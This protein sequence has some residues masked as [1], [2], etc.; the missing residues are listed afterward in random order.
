[1]AIEDVK[2][3]EVETV[4]VDTVEVDTV[5]VDTVEVDTVEVDTVEVD[6]VEVDTVEV[7]SIERGGPKVD[8]V[9]SD[10]GASRV[11]NGGREQA[12][13]TQIPTGSIKR[14]IRTGK[15]KGAHVSRETCARSVCVC[16]RGSG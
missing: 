2:L 8:P 9:D 14:S 5:E 12:H 1:M 7:N 15:Q 11:S 16:V 13:P 3:G 10:G 6:T 4:E